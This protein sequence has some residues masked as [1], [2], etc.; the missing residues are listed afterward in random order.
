MKHTSIVKRI[1]A[2]AVVIAC[3]MGLTFT[4]VASANVIPADMPVSTTAYKAIQC[5][6]FAR[7]QSLPKDM[8]NFHLNAVGE[9]QKTAGGV[10]QLGYNGGLLDAYGYANSSKFGGSREAARRDAATKL[11]K[12]VGCNTNVT[13]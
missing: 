4:N 9:E 13:I 3:I 7:A 10:F 2:G 6:V 5:F 11:Y 1:S 8:V 12:L